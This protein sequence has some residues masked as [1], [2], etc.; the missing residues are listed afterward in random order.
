L[1]ENANFARYPNVAFSQHR[2]MNLLP[3]FSVV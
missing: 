3:S 1:D 2:E